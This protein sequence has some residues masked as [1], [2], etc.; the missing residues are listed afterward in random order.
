MKRHK[1]YIH[2]TLGSDGTRRFQIEEHPTSLDQKFSIMDEDNNC[3]YT[4]K[5]TLFAL[6]DK[7]MLSDRHGNELFKIR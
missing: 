6:G 1:K 7:L 2:K 5:S 3:L 4:V